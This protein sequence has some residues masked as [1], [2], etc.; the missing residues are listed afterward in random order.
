MAVK[1]RLSRGGTK[2]KPFYSIV[3]ADG[4][5]PRDGRF[6]EKIGSYNP[7]LAKDD[8]N[9]VIIKE[10]RAKHWLSVGALPS[11]RVAMFFGK[12]G[13]IAMPAQKNNPE[14]SKPKE[15]AQLRMEEKAEK[16]RAVKEAAEQAR[17]EAE[18]AA[19]A[20][21]EAP[22][23]ETAPAEEETTPVAE[24]APVEEVKTE[25]AVAE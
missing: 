2:K 1:I 15:K 24:E 10:D 19:K 21:T 11:D 12:A 7:M 25:E 16:E 13:I 20:A 6:I 22:A 17:L 9:R 5:S 8:A 18:E 14:K 3:V 4:R 23:E